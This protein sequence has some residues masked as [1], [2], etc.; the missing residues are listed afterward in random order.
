[1]PKPSSYVEVEGVRF[2][3]DA[4]SRKALLCEW[5]GVEQWVPKSQMH[6]DV[7]PDS[8]ELPSEGTLH[9]KEFIIDRWFEE[10]PPEPSVSLGRAIALSETE[11]GLRVRL[12]EGPRAGEEIGMPK[13]AVAPDSEV[14][15]D[16]DVGVFRV[17]QWFAVKERL[18]PA[19]ARE[20][21]AGQE[22]RSQGAKWKPP[23]WSSGDD[24]IPF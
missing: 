7:E 9:V 16:C 18:V 22:V 8:I 6:P 4:K 17:M 23:E 21:S 2:L 5:Q 13:K 10:R 24:D 12:L 15:G 20:R 14:K 1:M 11:R 19:P 3:R